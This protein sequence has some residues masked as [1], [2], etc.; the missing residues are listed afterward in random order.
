MFQPVNIGAM[1]VKNRFVHSAT[2]EVMAALDGRITDAL[3]KRYRNLAK[4]EVGLVIP[5]HMY[6]HPLGNAHHAQIGTP[7]DSASRKTP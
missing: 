4:G 3:L 5:G 2:H 1:A 6:V 7:P